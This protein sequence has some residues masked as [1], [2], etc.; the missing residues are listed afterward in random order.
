MACGLWLNL[1]AAS[2][3]PYTE[4]LTAQQLDPVTS[5]TVGGCPQTVRV[6]LLTSETSSESTGTAGCDRRLGSRQYLYRRR[7]I[8]W[9]CTPSGAVRGRCAS[10]NPAPWSSRRRCAFRPA[11]AATTTQHL[12]WVIAR[13]RRLSLPSAAHAQSSGG[14]A[15]GA[16]SPGS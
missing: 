5:C 6:E 9:W 13:C 16:T 8:G 7:C 2:A 12:C 10:G 4:M 1:A 11:F 3:V 15:E 14:C